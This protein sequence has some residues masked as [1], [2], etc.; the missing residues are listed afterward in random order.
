MKCSFNFIGTIMQFID[1]SAVTYSLAK[2]LVK[3]KE[4]D[5][6]DAK[7][8]VENYKESNQSYGMNVVMKKG[9]TDIVS[10]AKELFDGQ[11]SSGN[12]GAFRI[13]SIV[14]AIYQSLHLNP[15]E[16]LNTMDFIDDLIHKMDQVG[17]VPSAIFCFLRA[18]KPITGIQ[19]ENPFRRAIQYAISLGGDIDTISS[20][21]G[22]VAG[23]FYGEGKILQYCKNSEE[24]RILED[25][26]FELSVSQ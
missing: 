3:Q 11:G 14:S 23:A 8:F 1:D 6:Y 7:Q 22:A 12:V 17:K 20:I 2:S 25:K 24:F 15:N 21:T 5:V 16:E 10:L 9:Y 26:L 19:I 13:A 4:L 18:Q